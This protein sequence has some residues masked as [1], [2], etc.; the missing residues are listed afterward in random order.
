MIA[1]MFNLLLVAAAIVS[2]RMTI[3]KAGKE[4]PDQVGR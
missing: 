4:A 3:P 1:L 2:I